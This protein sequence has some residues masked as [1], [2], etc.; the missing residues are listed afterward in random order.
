MNDYD[1]IEI[2]S[3]C[4]TRKR[5]SWKKLEKELNDRNNLITPINNINKRLHTSKIKI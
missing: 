5:W 2:L 3:L 4:I 1:Y